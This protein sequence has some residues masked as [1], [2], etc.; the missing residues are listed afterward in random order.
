MRALHGLGTAIELFGAA[1]DLT[2]QTRQ[3]EWTVAQ[4]GS[5]FLDAEYAKIDLIRADGDSLQAELSLRSARSWALATD[6]DEAG[7]YIVL[8]RKPLIGSFG[9]ARIRVSVPAG[10]HVSLKLM[11]CELRCHDI[12]EMLELP[13]AAH[14]TLATKAPPDFPLT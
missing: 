3:F 13:G 7:V 14:H 10:V 11:R 6:Q 2:R 4:D 8:K 5:F 12:S 1:R 9:G